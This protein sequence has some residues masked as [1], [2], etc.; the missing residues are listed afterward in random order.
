[1]PMAHENVEKDPHKVGYFRKNS[2]KCQYCPDGPICPQTKKNYHE[3]HLK[4]YSVYLGYITLVPTQLNNLRDE[5]M[6]LRYCEK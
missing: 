6:S 2:K 3:I 5:P 1:M 4:F